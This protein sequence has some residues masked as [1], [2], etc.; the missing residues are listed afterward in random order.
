MKGFSNVLCVHELRIFIN[1][2]N[3]QSRNLKAYLNKEKPTLLSF[4]GFDFFFQVLLKSDCLFWDFP[5]VSQQKETKENEKM[6]GLE[7]A[8]D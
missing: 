7:E 6:E 4:H 1:T 5:T 3:S 2:G 8:L